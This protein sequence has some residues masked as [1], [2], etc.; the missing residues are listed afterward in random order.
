MPNPSIIS[1]A[2]ALLAITELMQCDLLTPATKAYLAEVRDML[3]AE[4]EK[5]KKSIEPLSA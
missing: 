1:D 2:K 5:A 3:Q 4:I